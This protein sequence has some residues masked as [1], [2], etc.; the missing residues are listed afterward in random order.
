MGVPTLGCDDPPPPTRAEQCKMLRNEI[1]AHEAA[2]DNSDEPDALLQAANAVEKA[3]AAVQL[4]KLP[5]EEVA[6]VR[7]RY[8][9]MAR[10]LGTTSRD[11]AHAFADDDE[12]EKTR[13]RDRLATSRAVEKKVRKALSQTCPEK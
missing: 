3:G 13:V 2:I 1:A 7:D 10:D 4:L 6:A 5:D 8:V 11:A 12:E 9:K